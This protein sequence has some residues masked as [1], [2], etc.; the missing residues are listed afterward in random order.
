MQKFDEFLNVVVNGSPTPPVIPVLDAQ[1]EPVLE[2]VD[3]LRSYDASLPPTAG[4]ST[5]HS[6]RPYSPSQVCA[7]DLEDYNLLIICI[8]LDFVI[9]SLSVHSNNSFWMPYIY[10][11]RLVECFCFFF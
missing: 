10:Y 6:T 4:P 3:F 2:D 8:V 11:I 9:I 7:Q 1:S 5:N